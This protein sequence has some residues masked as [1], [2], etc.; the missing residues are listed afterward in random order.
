MKP[1][2]AQNM[3]E[4]IR[5]IYANLKPFGDNY[6]VDAELADCLVRLK[7]ALIMYARSTNDPMVYA[8]ANFTFTCPGSFCLVPHA[9]H[10]VLDFAMLTLGG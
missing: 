1:C 4:I 3:A 5:R 7:L 8:Y 6:M 10:E 2:Q 9:I